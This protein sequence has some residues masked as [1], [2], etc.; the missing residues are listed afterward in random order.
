MVL[1]I[2]RCIVGGVLRN[3]RERKGCEVNYDLYVSH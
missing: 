1:T 3:V 2:R